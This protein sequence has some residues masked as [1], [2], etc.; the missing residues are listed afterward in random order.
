MMGLEH[1][2]YG[3]HLRELG[4]FSLEQWRLRGELI[5]LYSDLK[6]S[7]GEVGGFLCSQITSNRM[8]V[9]GLKLPQGRF[10]LDIRNNFF[11]ERTVRY[12]NRLPREVVKSPSPL[13]HNSLL[14]VI[15]A[16][17]CQHL[18]SQAGRTFAENPFSLNKKTKLIFIK[19]PSWSDTAQLPKKVWFYSTI[20]NLQYL[21]FKVHKS[22][23]DIWV[24]LPCPFL[25]PLEICCYLNCDEIC[26]H[27]T[28]LF[29]KCC[30]VGIR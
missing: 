29:L 2:S 12:W 10:R 27:R 18:P 11:S 24:S 17:C 28:L 9:S 23:S 5:T 3:K 14:A 1:K 25:T 4:L 8:R 19:V 26:N 30:L 16:L 7:C 20:S 6:G 22:S 13:D 15:A 21:N